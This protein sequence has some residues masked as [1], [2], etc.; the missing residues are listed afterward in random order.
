M[1]AKDKLDGIIP[2]CDSRMLHL[3]TEAARSTDSNIR[4][5]RLSIAYVVAA[6]RS[7]RSTFFPLQSHSI[8]IRK[9]RH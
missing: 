1:N 4:M 5:R 3:L 9:I 7:R 6:R 2:L 8:T